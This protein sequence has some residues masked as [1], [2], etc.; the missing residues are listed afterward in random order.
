[1]SDPLKTVTENTV[2]ARPLCR[3]LLLESQYHSTSQVSAVLQ[4]VGE[5][6]TDDSQWASS[7]EA[8]KEP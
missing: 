6:S 3:L 4:H 5:H 2:I 7:K 8:A 1:M